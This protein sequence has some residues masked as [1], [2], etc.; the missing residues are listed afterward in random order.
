MMARDK[1][2]FT[3]VTDSREQ[4]PYEFEMPSEVN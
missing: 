4:R 2:G 1:S 3:I